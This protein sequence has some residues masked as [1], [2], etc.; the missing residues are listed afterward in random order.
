MNFRRHSVVELRADT[1]HMNRHSG[2][3]YISCSVRGHNNEES[4]RTTPQ[5]QAGN[6]TVTVPSA[7][8]VD[9][10]LSFELRLFMLTRMLSDKN[11]HCIVAAP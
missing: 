9:K 10:L 3:S 8:S 2:A 4:T 11:V 5:T 1:G 7:A 6:V